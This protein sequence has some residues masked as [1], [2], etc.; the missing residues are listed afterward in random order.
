[1][2][3]TLGLVQYALAALKGGGSLSDLIAS[4]TRAGRN[5]PSPAG[6][7]KIK[8]DVTSGRSQVP[9]TDA[10]KVESR[11]YKGLHDARKFESYL[12]ADSDVCCHASCF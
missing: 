12:F 9:M 2:A 4:L 6:E 3:S 8:I 1:M 5:S 11:V 10:P 7:S